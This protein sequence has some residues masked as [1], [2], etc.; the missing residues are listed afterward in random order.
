MQIP[1]ITFFRD[2]I[3]FKALFITLNIFLFKHA[4]LAILN[5]IDHGFYL[6]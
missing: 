2:I 5:K 6:E 4:F 3:F 1:N